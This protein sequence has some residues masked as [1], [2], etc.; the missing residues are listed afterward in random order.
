VK[1][2]LRE[3]APLLFVFY[4]ALWAT[5]VIAWADPA[6]R[7]EVPV[8]LVAVGVAATPVFIA[9]ALWMFRREEDGDANR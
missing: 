5:T 6:P 8:W 2:W 3:W 1:K 9:L 7:R 4:V